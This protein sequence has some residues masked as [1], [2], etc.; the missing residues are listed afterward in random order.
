MAEE[1]IAS[2]DLQANTCP[3]P[4]VWHP[5]VESYSR[6]SR[7]SGLWLEKTGSREISLRWISIPSP[8]RDASSEFLQWTLY[9]DLRVGLWLSWSDLQDWHV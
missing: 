6:C 2:L 7:I 8:V 9:N 3:P 1:F 4:V 5:D